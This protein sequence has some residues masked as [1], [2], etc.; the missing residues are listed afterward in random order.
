[1]LLKSS[2][3]FAS[4]ASIGMFATP[5]ISPVDTISSEASS[6][7]DFGNLASGCNEA[8]LQA[9]LPA[10][11]E[12]N[13]DRPGSDYTSFWIDKDEEAFV[14]VRRCQDACRND[15]RCSAF[16][17]VKPGVQGTQGRCYLKTSVPPPRESAC[18]ISGVVRPKTGSDR[19]RNYAATAVR[20]NQSNINGQCG[21]SGRRWS[22]DYQS[23]YSWC[24]GVPETS[25]RSETE[26][27]QTV[28][29]ECS[30]IDVMLG[31]LAQKTGRPR[32]DFRVISKERRTWGN[33][34]NA[35]HKPGTRCPANWIPIYGWRVLINDGSNDLHINVRQL[36]SGISG[37]IV[38][39]NNFDLAIDYF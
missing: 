38:D 27:R 18:C 17:Y 28:L 36:E 34:C 9:S 31:K 33:S 7:Y 3:I 23:H 19:C 22:S 24:M 15:H 25:T 6:K 8:V 30:A 12:T 16:T 2:L 26:A 39:P 20:Q 1:M 5:A 14:A 37:C 32:S 13:T 10:P 35:C 21:Y 4:I 29:I 11:W